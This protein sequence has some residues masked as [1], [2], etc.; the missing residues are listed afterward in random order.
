[1]AAQ[2]Y[3]DIIPPNLMGLRLPKI[4]TRVFINTTIPRKGKFHNV[5]GAGEQAGLYYISLCALISGLRRPGASEYSF[6]SFFRQR[7]LGTKRASKTLQFLIF[8][9]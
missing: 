6:L 8:L 7:S 1:M 3:A 2:I 4:L 5:V 9:I